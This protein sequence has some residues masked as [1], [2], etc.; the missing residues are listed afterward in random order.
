M[1]VN[2]KTYAII[3]SVILAASAAYAQ[4][5]TEANDASLPKIEVMAEKSPMLS[6][7]DQVGTKLFTAKKTT[8]ADMAE[9]PPV[10]TNNHR[11]LAS[12]L[13]GLLI[14]EVNN[15]SFASFN[16]RGIG[17][18]HESF[19]V[20]ILKDGVPISADQV[21]Y[22]ANYFM[23]PAQ[24]LEGIE[25]FRGGA[26][27]L[28]GPQP[29]AALNFVTKRPE[30]NSGRRFSTNQTIGSWELFSSHNEFSYGDEDVAFMG[31]YHHRSS[32]GYRRVNG[33]F[34]VNN[35]IA[36][37]ALKTDAGAR[38]LVDMD[39]YDATFGEPGGLTL[40]QGEGLAS[41]TDN[42]RQ[43]TLQFDRLQ[44]ERYAPTVHL[45]YDLS[46]DTAVS[47]K[48]F[49]THYRR[50]SRR[51]DLGGAPAFGGI[52]LADT[53]TIALQ[54]FQ[55]IGLDSRVKQNYTL[56]EENHTLTAG[57]FGNL[58]RS[59]LRTEK[60]DNPSANTGILNR[61]VYRNS[62]QLSAFVE[63]QFN[64]G[65]LKVVPGFRMENIYFDIN[66][67]VD[68]SSATGE[69]RRENSWYNE[70]LFFIGSAYELESSE[71]YANVSES[72]KPIA[73]ADLIPLNTGD[74]ISADLD[75]AKAWTAEVGYRGYLGSAFKYDASIFRTDYD[76]Q[77]GRV[78]NAIQNV[79][80]GIYQG[81]ELAGQ[82]ALIEGTKRLIGCE[83]S[84]EFG[85][86]KFFANATLLD[87]EFVRGPADGKTPQYAPDYLIRSGVT[88]EY[89]EDFKLSLVGTF[90]DNHFADDGNTA[91]RFIPS[92]EVFDLLAEY[93][94]TKNVAINGGINNLFDE[95]YYS[96]IRSNGIDPANPVN[97]FVG[98]TFTY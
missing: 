76:N 40:E 61:L 64:I 66:E 26:A 22:P 79:G 44:I 91:N 52:P 68:T 71:I 82:L 11:L 51:Q 19:N 3:A 24:T 69:L 90:V 14:S 8:V 60:G 98:A 42:R 84:K 25:L 18:P 45:D 47:A 78:A 35:Y 33:G 32:E 10:P 56:F 89:G 49:A 28:Y 31:T 58:L 59:P 46:R 67:T 4:D 88:Y 21:G 81:V 13:P 15:E 80:R 23:P 1:P 95:Q 16:Y 30:F 37:A 27:L 29:G 41:F 96:R 9:L 34:D 36:K 65:A 57:V 38:W 50:Y 73:F 6:L 55:N 43:S 86:L 87:A 83:P 17:D 39:V 12:Q 62:A 92:Y 72:Y 48:V 85:E 5:L 7:P 70:P 20:N 75:P 94:I 74:S 93:R 54:E 63:N 97:A 2:T 53:T 77:F